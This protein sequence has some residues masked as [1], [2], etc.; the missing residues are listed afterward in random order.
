MDLEY[1][2]GAKA[3]TFGDIYSYG[4]LLLEMFTAKRPTNDLLSNEGSLCKYVATALPEQVKEVVD[5]LLLA[6]LKSND[7]LENVRN[8]VEIN[9]SEMSNFFLS[10]FRIGLSC[11]STSPLDRRSMKDVTIKLQKIKKAFSTFLYRN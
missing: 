9:E 3:T 7:G 5:P 6:Y 8:L 2:T 4:I 11:A 1:W 10:I